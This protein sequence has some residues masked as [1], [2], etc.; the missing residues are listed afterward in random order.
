MNSIPKIK[1]P[2]RKD[3]QK[4]AQIKM[5]CG[6]QQWGKEQ[7]EQEGT[8]VVK[9]DRKNKSRIIIASASLLRDQPYFSRAVAL[10]C[11]LTLDQKTNVS[12]LNEH[13]LHCRYKNTTPFILC[14]KQSLLPSICLI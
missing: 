5:M 4:T 8:K 11:R 10:L 7:K 2:G 6:F 1:K 3:I 9:R 12:W 14:V 13:R